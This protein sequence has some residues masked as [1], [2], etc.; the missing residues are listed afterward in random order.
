MVLEEFKDVMPIELPKKLPPRR[1][2]D[3]AIELEPGAKPLAF[4]P[5]HMAPPK[6]KELRRQLKELLDA[7][8]I[9]PSQS[10]MVRQCYSKRS[11]MVRFDYASTTGL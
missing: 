11:M 3:H 4:A 7:G 2:V 10:H 6:L 9:R 1:E 8:Y 5:Y